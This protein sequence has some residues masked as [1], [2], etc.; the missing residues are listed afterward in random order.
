MQCTHIVT[1]IIILIIIYK[2]F[3]IIVKFD[4]ISKYSKK[5]LSAR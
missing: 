5:L 4:F 3:K 1:Y 2:L